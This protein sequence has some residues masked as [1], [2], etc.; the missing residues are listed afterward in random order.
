MSIEIK[1]EPT[2]P[3]MSWDDFVVKTPKFSIALDGFVSTGPKFDESGPRANMNHHED[4]DRLAT[5]A[6]CAQALMAVRQGLF[7]K[8]RDKDGAKA[9]IYAN[10]CDEDV[11]TS[12][13]ILKNHYLATNTMNPALNRL[14][15]MEDALDSTAGAYPFP[16]DL[17][18]LQELAWVFSPY[19]Q[20]RMSGGLEK[21]NAEAFIEIVTDVC[22]RISKHIVGQGSSIPLD[23]RY[24]R[25]DSG[26]DYVVVKEI[27]AHSRTG[28]FS[29]GIRA[30]VSVKERQDGRW[31][32]T[33]GRMSPFV[34]IDTSLIANAM[35]LEEC[36]DSNDR[37]GGGNSIIGS[38]RISGSSLPPKK[39]IEIINSLVK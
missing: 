21:R 17:P 27:G 15:A 5:R 34:F 33:I 2:T 37:W 6:T 23:L 1:M 35:N 38:P 39:V 19:R 26:K 32:Y 4:V 16:G 7:Q 12:V 31:Q 14:V 10:D 11:C 30:Y 28:M 3:P 9:I 18:A 8:F 22:N 25:I 13:F 36:N 29:D 24:D 20:F